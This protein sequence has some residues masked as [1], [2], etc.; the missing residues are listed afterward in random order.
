VNWKDWLKEVSTNVVAGLVVLALG[1]VAVSIWPPLRQWTIG[2][3]NVLYAFLALIVGIS[4]GYFSNA[5][6]KAPTKSN[7]PKSGGLRLD[8]VA[9]LFWLASD[10]QWAKQMASRGLQDR[11]AHGLEQAYHH[12]SELGLSTAPAG[13]QLLAHK[14]SVQRMPRQLND[15]ESSRIA[16]QIDSDLHSFSSLMKQHQPDFRP[17]PHH[18]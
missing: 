2:H 3:Q 14:N 10:L 15:T 17:D 9:N 16:D 8:R 13:Q 7:D 18:S 5:L 12:T 11:V 1:S 6:R 4:I